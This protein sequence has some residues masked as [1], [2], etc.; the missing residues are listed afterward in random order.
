MLGVML[1]INIS[2]GLDHLVK[3]L[4]T[5]LLTRKSA[6]INFKYLINV[7]YIFIY[8]FLQSML[9]RLGVYRLVVSHTFLYKKLDEYGKE[10]NGKILEK[11]IGE[12]KRLQA[13][14]KGKVNLMIMS[15]MQLTQEEKLSLTI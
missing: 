1:L 7:M 6:L 2:E 13:I 15:V 9:C 11:V 12:G 4:K 5:L 10:H 3:R 14:E 8:L